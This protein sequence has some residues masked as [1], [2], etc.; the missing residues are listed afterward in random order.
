MRT[1][2]VAVREVHVSHVK[3]QVPDVCNGQDAIEAVWNGEGEEILCEYSHTLE[4]DYWT[5]E[6]ACQ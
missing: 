1:F 4:P 6:E 5:V 3:I 2:I